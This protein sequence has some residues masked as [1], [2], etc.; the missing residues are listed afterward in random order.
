[1]WQYQHERFPLLQHGLL[2]AAFSFCAVSLSALLRGASA[3]PSWPSALTAFVCLLLFFLQLRI[4]DEFK[5]A[6]SDARYRPERPVP[7]GLVT[8]VEL[9]RVGCI[10]ALIQLWMAWWLQPLLLLPLAIVW[11]YMALMRVEF[12]LGSWLQR[13][14]F[15]YLWSHMLIVPLIDLF[16]T[17]CDWLPHQRAAPPGLAWFLAVS[18]FNGIVIEIGRK[19]W[20]P[21]QERVGVESYSSSWGLRPALAGWLTAMFLSLICA[22]VLAWQIALFWPI[23]STLLVLATLLAW[24]GYRFGRRPTAQGAAR[25]ETASGLWIAGLYFIL[26]CI[27]MGVHVWF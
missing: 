1:L 16:A 20:A 7:R 9:R 23:V 11:L 8:L 15:A 21:A 10:A 2:I 17:A 13:H 4:A 27:P 26:G 22:A 18:F 5:D 3:W 6:A 12:G 24:Q 19:T 25:L 14:P